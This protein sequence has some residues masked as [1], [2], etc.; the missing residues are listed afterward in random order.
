MSFVMWQVMRR[1]PRPLL[2]VVLLFIFSY[3]AR[4]RILGPPALRNGS[5]NT[6]PGGP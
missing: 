3:I 6:H 2:L 5:G 1:L 4:A